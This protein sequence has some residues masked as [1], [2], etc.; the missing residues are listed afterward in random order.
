MKPAHRDIVRLAVQSAVAAAATNLALQLTGTGE[1]FLAV[2]SA[3]LVLQTN[4]D[5]TLSSASSRMIGTVVGTLIGG[6]A[7]FITADTAISLSLAVVMLIMG[8][9][10]AWKPGWRYG[11]VAAA[12]LAVG[13]DAPVL[14]TA[15]NRG[16]AIFL[17]AGIGI[18]T[19]FLVWPET[20]ASRARR[21]MR[22]ALSACR[23]LVQRT[24]A[25]AVEGE[26]AEASE[27]HRRFSDAIIAA[28]DTARSIKVARGQDPACYQKA[29]HAIERLWHALVILDRTSE[30]KQGDRLPLRDETLSQ[31]RDIRSA[32]CEAL[33][34]AARFERMPED[35]LDEL[36]RLCRAV[37]KDARVDPESEDELANVGLVF[38]LSE[39]SRNMREIDAAIGAIR[40]SR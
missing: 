21:Q 3:V 33:A 16:I 24:L 37:W 26:E 14:E 39:V 11:I 27:T 35:E 10:V 34:C 25:A 2:I 7:L 32:A 6:A 38:G 30:T 12:G 29:V 17:G 31:I 40:A 15:L 5:E 18:A 9:L 8:A 22:E 13:S 1:A 4:R 19:G 23:E 36:G 20:A 28:G